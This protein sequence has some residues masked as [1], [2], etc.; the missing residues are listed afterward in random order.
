MC[1]TILFI[2][3]SRNFH[4][5]MLTICIVSK[6]VDME[7]MFTRGQPFNFPCQLH[8]S[9][10]ILRDESNTTDQKTGNIKELSKS[11]SKHPVH[12]L[13][14]LQDPTLRILNRHLNAK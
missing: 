11:G 6:S 10:V 2:V 9:A 1:T 8:R 5:Q 12:M 13:L 3:K 14:Q 7:P 4:Y